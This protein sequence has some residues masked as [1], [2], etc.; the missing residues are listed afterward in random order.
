MTEEESER[1]R[2]TEDDANCD[3][4]DKDPQRVLLSAVIFCSSSLLEVLQKF[5]SAMCHNVLEQDVEDLRQDV[6]D[7]RRKV[8]VGF[9]FKIQKPCCDTKPQRRAKHRVRFFVWLTQV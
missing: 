7:L 9:H 5:Y 8:R 1:E 3:T 6:E 4:K 2:E